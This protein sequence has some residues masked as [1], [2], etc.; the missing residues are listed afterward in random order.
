MSNRRHTT[1]EFNE[2]S[3]LLV[4]LLELLKPK[5]IVALGADA[6]SGALRLGL[7]VSPV[8]HPSYGGQVEF[9]DAIRELYINNY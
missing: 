3:D 2:C 8:R 4:C 5:R 9:A 7:R 1:R 6:H